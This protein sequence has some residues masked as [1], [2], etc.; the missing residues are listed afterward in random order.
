MR[1]LNFTVATGPAREPLSIEDAKEHLRIDQ[2]DE[3]VWLLDAIKATRNRAE[4]MMGRALIA[5]T[6]EVALSGWPATRV[7]ELPRP[8]LVSVTSV[9]YFDV[10]DAEFTLAASNYIV[11]TRTTPGRLVLKSTASWPG[12]ALR[13][14]NGVIIRYVAGY[15]AEAADVPAEIRAAMKLW[16]GDMYEVRENS[17]VGTIISPAPSAAEKLLLKYRVF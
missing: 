14:V 10:D 9:K 17:I 8:P 2:H 12:T 5:Q 11:D 1:I 15:G 6:L 4:G 7:I 3:D 16:L 13:D